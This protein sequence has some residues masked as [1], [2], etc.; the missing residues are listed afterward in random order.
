MLFKEETVDSRKRDVKVDIIIR[1][2]TYIS[3]QKYPQL[4]A[5]NVLLCI[6]HRIWFAYP[7]WRAVEVTW[8]LMFFLLSF[9]ISISFILTHN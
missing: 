2:I 4:C 5:H 1:I 6:L 9:L 3:A 7:P 8:V